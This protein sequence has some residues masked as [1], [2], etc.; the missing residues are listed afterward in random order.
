MSLSLIATRA[1]NTPLLIDQGKAEAFM[2]GLGGRIVGGVIEITN[3]IGALD[4]IAF[5][6]GRPSMG[7]LGDGL[8]RTYDKYSAPTYDAVENV[9][10]IA[11]EGTLVHKGAFIGASSGRTS[12][13]GLQTQIA[14][15]KRDAL[16]GKIKGAVFEVDSY[17]GEAA[18]AFDAADAVADLSAIIP[19]I[20]ILTENAHSSGYL[21]AAGARQ[22]IMP[23]FGG[24][25][26]I[27]ALI[28]HTD[29]SRKLENEGV[30]LTM[31]RGGRKKALG[32]P[33]E[34]LP[35]DVADQMQARVDAMRGRF[36][37]TIGRLRGNRF[38]E[39]QALATEADSFGAADALK[40]G[41]VDAIGKPAD[42]FEAFIA[43]VNRKK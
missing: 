18:G 14:R 37:E 3:G 15:V 43:E 40:L 34:P 27:G 10:I 1:L 28:I 41:L 35:A 23:E 12:Y 19:T 30:K 11:V 17:G 13:Q 39:E 25:G 9:A 8:G 24:A 4:H 32:N 22:I 42:A 29:M 20:S 16:A 2:L 36:A 38:T 26:S 5:E 7:K 31:I 33:V 21:M 6:N